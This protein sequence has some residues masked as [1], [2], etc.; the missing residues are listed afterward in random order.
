MDQPQELD[1]MA[2][3]EAIQLQAD[4][5][6][7]QIHR[8][9]EALGWLITLMMLVGLTPIWDYDY[10]FLVACF[11][12]LMALLVFPLIVLFRAQQFED[13]IQQ[14]RDQAQDQRDH[15]V[16]QNQHLIDITLSDTIIL[17]Y[18]LLY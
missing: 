12:W 18:Y 3:A 9:T 11:G 14:L 10:R 17:T 13:Q 6:I 2:A 1:M 15:L 5:L 4:Q 8:E 7:N 16:D